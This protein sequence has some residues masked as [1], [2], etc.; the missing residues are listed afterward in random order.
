[1]EEIAERAERQW[2]SV[3][4]V[5]KTGEDTLLIVVGGVARITGGRFC[6]LP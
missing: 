5:V 3:M 4:D 1:M 2:G 6:R